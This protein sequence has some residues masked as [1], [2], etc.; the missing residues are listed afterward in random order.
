MEYLDREYSIDKI[1]LEGAYKNINTKWL[2]DFKKEQMGNKVLESLVDTGRLSGTEYYS[3]ISNKNEIIAGIEDEKLYKENIKL[4]GEII[5]KRQE[6]EKICSELEQK[7]NSIKKEYFK[8]NKEIKN[9][10]NLITK[11]KNKQIN[12]LQYYSTLERLA[13]NNSVELKKY[14]NLVSYINIL[15][16]N[17]NINKNKLTEEI[18]LFLTELKSTINYQDYI[19]LLN[20]SNNFKNITNISQKLLVLDS[21]HRISDKL[22]LKNLNSFLRYIELS[23][24]INP[25]EFMDEETNLTDIIFLKLAKNKYEHEVIFLSYCLPKIKNYFLADITAQNYHKFSELFVKFKKILLSYSSE[26]IVSKLDKY[27]DLLLKYYKNNIQRD[28]IFAKTIVK[29]KNES[30]KSSVQNTSDALKY[31][32]NKFKGKKIKLVVTGGFHTAGLE[33]TLKN[34]GI[35][36]IVITPKVTENIDKA[37]EIYADTIKYNANI[38]TNSINIEPLS[39]ENVN[40]SFPKLLNDIFYLIKQDVTLNSLNNN[41]LLVEIN[42]FVDKHVKSL[43]SNISV[44]SWQ[45]TEGSLKDKNIK[46]SVTYLIQKGEKKEIETVAYTYPSISDS[47]ENL[48][49]NNLKK[50]VIFKDLFKGFGTTV[51]LIYENVVAPIA[52]NFVF[53]WIP[54]VSTVTIAPNLTA[55]PFAV[56]A[57]FGIFVF[58]LSHIIADHFVNQEERSF[59]ELLI[60]TTL[61]TG[62]FLAIEYAFPG[63]SFIAFVTSSIIHIIYNILVY[64]EIINLPAALIVKDKLLSKT[65]TIDKVDKIIEKSRFVLISLESELLKAYPFNKQAS[66]YIIRQLYKRKLIDNKNIFSYKAKSLFEE[67]SDIKEYFLT[68]CRYD[69]KDDN[70]NELKDNDKILELDLLKTITDLKEILNEKNNIDDKNLKKIESCVKELEYLEQLAQKGEININEDILPMVRYLINEIIDVSYDL[71]LLNEQQDEQIVKMLNSILPL[72]KQ[73]ILFYGKIE[74]SSIETIRNIANAFIKQKNIDMF[75]EIFKFITEI[76]GTNK[77]IVYLNSFNKIDRPIISVILYLFDSLNKNNVSIKKYLKDKNDIISIQNIIKYYKFDTQEPNTELYDFIFDAVIDNCDKFDIYSIFQKIYKLGTKNSINALNMLV[78]KMYNFITDD[79]NSLYRRQIVANDLGK[80]VAFAS[81]KN[82]IQTGYINITK[83]NELTKNNQIKETSVCIDGLYDERD[84]ENINEYFSFSPLIKNLNIKEYNI[85]RNL[86]YTEIDGKISEGDNR[87]YVI[88]QFEAWQKLIEANEISITQLDNLAEYISKIDDDRY[89]TSEEKFEIQKRFEEICDSINLMIR[90]F[91]KIDTYGIDYKDANEALRKIRT[92]FLLGLQRNIRTKKDVEKYDLFKIGTWAQGELEYVTRLNALINAIHQISAIKFRENIDKINVNSGDIQKIFLQKGDIKINAYNFSDNENGINNDISELFERLTQNNDTDIKD[93]IIYNDDLYWTCRLRVHS[94]SIYFDFKNRSI[95]LSFTESSNVTG[96]KLRLLYFKKVLKKLGFEIAGSSDSGILT[97][98]ASIDET[99][100]INNNTDFVDLAK[101][102]ILLFRHSDELDLFLNYIY[103]SNSDDINVVDKINAKIKSL[104]DIFLS[105]FMWFNYKDKKHETFKRNAPVNLYIN[106]A[107]KERFRELN[108]KIKQLNNKFLNFTGIPNEILNKGLITQKIIDEYIN[109]P[110]QRAFVDGKILINNNKFFVNN[111]FNVVED[112]IS[113]IEKNED[114]SIR[115][116]ELLNFIDNNKFNFN[117]ITNIGGLILKSGYIKLSDDRFLS[118][119]VLT[120][121][122]GTDFKYAYNEV[123]TIDSKRKY[124]NY[125]NLSKILSDNNYKIPGTIEYIS[126]GEKENRKKLFDGEIIQFDTPSIIADGNSAGNGYVFGEITLD[127]YN[128]D[129]NKILAISHTNPDDVDFI[130]NSKAII[131][132]TG[133]KISHSSIVTKEAGIPAVNIADGIW[134]KDKLYVQDILGQEFV[135]KE[136][137]KVL[138]NGETGHILIL[139]DIDVNLLNV[140]QHYIKKKDVEELI[141]LLN[142]NTNN[143]NLN[144][145][146][147]CMF[148]QLQNDEIEEILKKDINDNVKNKLCNLLDINLRQT[149]RQIDKTIINIKDTDNIAVKYILLKSIR[150]KAESLKNKLGADAGVLARYEIYKQQVLANGYN[151]VSQN[152]D[153]AK[154]YLEKENYNINEIRYILKFIKRMEVLNSYLSTDDEYKDFQSKKEILSQLCEQLNNKILPLIQNYEVTKIQDFSEINEEHFNIYGSKTTELAKISKYVNKYSNVEVPFGIGISSNV[155]QLLFDEDTLKIYKQLNENFEGAVKNKDIVKAHSIADDIVTLIEKNKHNIFKIQL[156]DGQKYAVRSSG[157]GED[158]GKHSFA[159]MGKTTLN[160]PKQQVYFEILKCWKSFYS[161]TAVNYM[162]RTEQVVKP[163]ILVQKFI[164][165]EK[166][167][168][169][170]S[171][172]NEGN[173]IISVGYGLGEGIVDNSVPVDNIE[174]NANNGQIINYN[175]ANKNLRI[176]PKQNETGTEKNVI[177]DELKAKSRA[178]NSK[179]IE[180]LTSVVSNLE[181]EYYYPIDVEFTIKDGTIY[182]LQ[183]RPITI[184][185]DNN[186]IDTEGYQNYI[187][188]KAASILDNL[189]LNKVTRLYKYWTI[190]VSPI[191]E[192]LFIVIPFALFATNPLAFWMISVIGFAFSHWLADVIINKTVNSLAEVRSLSDILKI[193]GAGILFTT[194]FL[195]ANTLLPGGPIIALLTA[196]GVHSIYNYISTKTDKLPVAT[197]FNVDDKIRE[198]KTEKEEKPF[199]LKTT[200]HSK[201]FKDFDELYSYNKELAKEFIVK[202]HENGLLDYDVVSDIDE[203]S[204]NYEKLKF[205]YECVNSIPEVKDRVNNK[206]IS[207]ISLLPNIIYSLESEER[208]NLLETVNKTNLDKLK[209]GQNPDKRIIKVFSE[210]AI[211]MYDKDNTEPFEKIMEI[212]LNLASKIK[213]DRYFQDKYAPI[214]NIIKTLNSAN[215]IKKEH[216]GIVLEKLNKTTPT[217]YI[218]SIDKLFEIFGTNK[219]VLE[220]LFKA[221][222]EQDSFELDLLPNE[223]ILEEESINLIADNI[224]LLDMRFVCLNLFNK[225][226]DIGKEFT[227]LIIKKLQENIEKEKNV[228]KSLIALGQIYSGMYENINTKSIMPIDELNNLFKENEINA[229][230]IKNKIYLSNLYD[231]NPPDKYDSNIVY[232]NNSIPND[233]LSWLTLENNTSLNYDFNFTPLIK[234]VKRSLFK[235]AVMVE[236]SPIFIETDGVFENEEFDNLSNNFDYLQEL[237]KYNNL[238]IAKMIETDFKTVNFADLMLLEKYINSMIDQLQKINYDDAKICRDISNNLFDSLEEKIGKNKKIQDQSETKYWEWNGKSLKIEGELT[239]NTLINIIHQTGIAN[240]KNNVK[241]VKEYSS[242]GLQTVTAKNR[243]ETVTAYNLSKDGQI[244]NEIYD[245]ISGLSLDRHDVELYINDSMVV[246]SCVLLKHS[247]DI[248]INFDD[249]NRE[250]KIY[251]SEGH[252]EK[253]NK[254]R[255]LYFSK[256]LEELGFKVDTKIDNIDKG[257]DLAAY[258]MEATLNKDSGLTPQTNLAEIGGKI[259]KLFEYSINLDIKL[260]DMEEPEEAI[261]DFIDVFNVGEI[262]SNYDP[263]IDTLKQ[264]APMFMPKPSNARIEELVKNMN[265]ILK[266]F[267]LETIPDTVLNGERY[268]I[269]NLSENKNNELANFFQ[270][271]ID[272][273]F[274]KPL[275]KAYI[276]GKIILNKNGILIKNSKYNGLENILKILSEEKNEITNSAKILNYLPEYK[277]NYDIFGK[278]TI[279]NSDLEARTGI[280]QLTNG[281]YLF[282][283]ELINPKN[284][285]IEYAQAEIVSYNKR[286]VLTSMELKDI[287]EKEGY[288]TGNIEIK[289]ESK[290][291]RDIEH[292]EWPISNEA[293]FDIE[294]IYNDVG[295]EHFIEEIKLWKEDIDSLKTSGID[296]GLKVKIAK[297]ADKLYGE[298]K[299]SDAEDIIYTAYK[300]GLVSYIDYNWNNIRMDDY[301]GTTFFYNSIAKHYPE[302]KKLRKAVEQTVKILNSFEADSDFGKEIKKI[303][304]NLTNDLL[305]NNINEKNIHIVYKLFE[306]YPGKVISSVRKGDISI[307]DAMI[308]FEAILPLYEEIIEQNFKFDDSILF[309]FKKMALLAYPV[310]FDNNYD[311]RKKYFY[312][313]VNFLT[314]CIVKTEINSLNYY[315][316]IVEIAENVYNGNVYHNDEIFD[317]NKYKEAI[318]RKQDTI[319]IL[320]R[321]QQVSPVDYAIFANDI[322]KNVVLNETTLTLLFKSLEETKQYEYELELNEN[323]LNDEIQN[324][325]VN[326]CTN[327]NMGYMCHYFYFE[328]EDGEGNSYFTKAIIEKLTNIYKNS[329]NE[330]LKKSVAIALGEIYSVMYEYIDNSN[331]IS[332]D[333]LN[334]FYKQNK[335]NYFLAKN[336]SYISDLYDVDSTAYG[337]HNSYNRKDR[338]NDKKLSITRLV[339]A[340]KA[341]LDYEFDI[342][343]LM[344]KNNYAG[345]FKIKEKAPVFIKTYKV[346]SLDDREQLSSLADMFD[347]VKNLLEN[348]NKAMQTLDN[349]KT[350]N[351]KEKDVDDLFEYLEKMISCMRVISKAD[352]DMCEISLKKVRA[353]VNQNNLDSIDTNTLNTLINTVHQTGIEDFKTMVRYKN[354]NEDLEFQNLLK[355]EHKGTEIKAYNLSEKETV[356]PEI[357]KMINNLALDKHSIDLFFK[358]DMVVWSM[359]LLAHSVDVIVNFSEQDRGIKIYYNEGGDDKSNEWRIDYFNKIL[360]DNLNFGNIRDDDD[361]YVEDDIYGIRVGLDNNSGLTD[362]TDLADIATKIIKLFEYSINLDLKFEG[363]YNDP[364]Y[365]YFGP[366]DG[367]VRVEGQIDGYSDIFIKG[368]MPFNYNLYVSDTIYPEPSYMDKPSGARIRE[369]KDYM[370]NI[371]ESLGLE[372]IP[373]DILNGKTVYVPNGDEMKNGYGQA[374]RNFF[375]NDIDEYFNKPIERAFIKGQI[376]LDNNGFLKKNESYDA[377]ENF[378]KMF[379]KQTETVL[380]N[381]AKIIEAIPEYDITYY[382]IENSFGSLIARDGTIKLLNGD[383]L[384]IKELVDQSGKVEYAQVELVPTQSE[385]KILTDEEVKKIL[386]DDGYEIENTRINLSETENIKNKLK[387]K[388]IDTNI[389][390]Q[391][392]NARITSKGKKE[393]NI[394]KVSF[395]N[396]NVDED[397]VLFKEFTTPKDFSAIKNAGG[398]ITTAGGT[399]SHAAI[400]TKELGKPSLIIDNSQW[401]QDEKGK[402]LE[403]INYKPVGKK[404]LKNIEGFGVIETQ[405]KEKEIIKI[406]HGDKIFMSAENGFIVKLS[407]DENL[408]EQKGEIIEYLIQLKQQRKEFWKKQIFAELNMITKVASASVAE[409]LLFNTWDKIHNTNLPLTDKEKIK[410][411]NKAEE[412]KDNMYENIDEKYTAN[413]YENTE[414]NETNVNKFTKE[415]DIVGLDKIKSNQKNMFGGKTVELAKIIEELK[416]FKE[417]DVIVPAGIG[418]SKNVCEQYCGEKFI[419]SNNILRNLINE[420]KITENEKIENLRKE[421]IGIIEKSKNEEIEKYILKN[422]DENKYY[423]VRSSGIGEDGKEHAFAGMGESVLNVK[424]SDIIKEIKNV[425]KSFYNEQAI[426]Y[427]LNTGQFIQPAVLIQE[428]VPAAYAGVAFSR[429]EKGYLIINVTKGLGDKVVDGTVTPDEIEVNPITGEKVD[430]NVETIL[431]PKQIKELNDTIMFLEEKAGYPTDN[432]FAFDK[433]GN[434]NILQRR[435]DTKF[436]DIDQVQQA[437]IKFVKSNN[438]DVSELFCIEHE[439]KA[440]SVW[441]EFDKRS[442][443]IMFVA[444]DNNFNAEDKDIVLRKI[445]D[446]VNNDIVVRGKTNRQLPIFSNI[447]QG[448]LEILPPVPVDNLEISEEDFDDLENSKNTI[449]LLSAA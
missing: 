74:D 121:P 218:N 25:V 86:I 375:Q 250:I 417:Y 425:W 353:D 302:N 204:N 78:R 314:D 140:L 396:E 120:E 444:E 315:K 247:V 104:Q 125:N 443:Q 264:S 231:N 257:I 105:G 430:P 94:I 66:E 111:N 132:T 390:G 16:I 223:E 392:I 438:N 424:G 372:K 191:I 405:K 434:L 174:I 173:S 146:I 348:N 406:R 2:S 115:Q 186:T 384:Y 217:E 70:G 83:I 224:N 176:L 287:L 280:M 339:D 182:I 93:F 80:I 333:E 72:Y 426:E 388:I 342:T 325:I 183:I 99:T 347:A 142:K 20:E 368:E 401:K 212:T 435:P 237:L 235:D 310:K 1:Y 213:E 30:V 192:T 153:I 145:L 184:L 155:L 359:Q 271:D 230:L 97:L 343:S 273:Y 389:T 194:V 319:N 110:L 221:L 369:F 76:Y 202:A 398:I 91:S 316:Y 240:F 323:A 410:L 284:D 12:A 354:M 133:S 255:M 242:T 148:F 391:L 113:Y 45:L 427:M 67:Y 43:H 411:K 73:T 49:N 268:N 163:A 320:T 34:N 409:I 294:E 129:Q 261:D 358:D 84:G 222:K 447:A 282:I 26:N 144:K 357:Y 436:N 134:N 234:N 414:Y 397:T 428:M 313:F 327:L 206:N 304:N 395:D 156:E 128:S 166:S 207:D 228:K 272:K 251:Y 131:T 286:T 408:E 393:Y 239:L 303:S 195:A 37:K 39:Q 370:N 253:G 295:I 208:L 216:I 252:S 415:N 28:E 193:G 232:E 215:N 226:K 416:E 101:K 88:H 288:K 420:N 220:N 289:N 225:N 188:I 61:F 324:L 24:N 336:N 77:H 180:K 13:L 59:K 171:R 387:E 379:K 229:V 172:N 241:S 197:I 51:N 227:E 159:G 57:I 139:D 300:L 448:K 198:L 312:D 274:N 38:L 161:N 21:T 147:E 116:A 71:Y 351:A 376:K 337:T 124:V 17:N 385:R 114:D 130:L 367:E 102:V 381:T 297:L 36:Y 11:Y 210:I 135:L 149:E 151:F 402:Y 219:I 167:G 109:N 321:F 54:F 421:I 122:N 200:R 346:Q 306:Y 394:L 270:K 205:W 263:R 265:N 69:K 326:N 244:N 119:K 283:K 281:E 296:N 299:Y 87:Q 233:K 254:Y 344:L 127:K 236:K 181:K 377:T 400:T 157:I 23:K 383:S 107:E 169:V 35:S 27:Q 103:F 48:S 52:E 262:D 307:D 32:E 4:L 431:T 117:T 449:N 356:N 65:V 317:E 42:K 64:K 211:L 63:S 209:Q 40:V 276:Q 386:K 196:A 154:F 246:W 446:R 7:I 301:E 340:G 15:K 165:G 164:E 309:D 55:V 79:K 260:E 403:V 58:P 175:T 378:E 106:E 92:D 429:N 185:N 158:G 361:L 293:T 328:H 412:V 298:Q 143:D 201:L 75:D 404:E 56:T 329:A 322:F 413:Y 419:V 136:K 60:P 422:I 245:L 108:Y 81:D 440:I 44:V 214:F 308:L 126:T 442:G 98:R 364:S 291:E 432:E 189:F 373:E 14:P 365:D 338:F 9:L 305:K 332:I 352:A 82:N 292:I 318:Q 259:I 277:I 187:N 433:D 249:N 445:E 85:N 29:K 19:K 275:E 152:I 18:K 162:L 112:I 138:L 243:G 418:L 279:Q 53:L 179:E 350:E 248:V 62:V 150:Q 423:A 334:N 441:I 41:D 5:S 362:K 137:T 170:F 345:E 335:M 258:S 68:I 10:E 89:L 437:D 341:K 382:D 199:M 380:I 8:N 160:V 95:N 407:E 178:L 399:L 190:V 269:N 96:N 360:K 349:I 203:L 118:V 355:S 47:E 267:D 330:K 168:V 374:G 366:T 177:E 238:A 46:Y 285:N 311:K 6:I 371:L 123:V 256:V 363:V 50:A 290:K 31:I 90:Y 278:V 22:K 331:I 100:G 3:V 141:K 439:N 33:K 266:K